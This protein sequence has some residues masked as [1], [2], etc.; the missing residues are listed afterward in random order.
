MKY[1]FFGLLTALFSLMFL[2]CCISTSKE[3]IEIEKSMS[4]DVDLEK[5]AEF[6]PLSEFEPPQ[7]PDGENVKH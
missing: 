7:E 5:Y 1:S 3:I 4:S 6:L 2:A